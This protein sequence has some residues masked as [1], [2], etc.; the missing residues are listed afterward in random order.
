[1][2]AP[3]LYL[4]HAATSP[5]RPA[6]LAAMAAAW[7]GPAGNAAARH[8][9][10]RHA[11]RLVEDARERVAA[12]VGARPDDVIFT[13][14]ATEASNLAVRGA[15]H[16]RRMGGR[17]IAATAIEHAATRRSLEALAAEGW[18]V[19]LLEAD[20]AGRLRADALA[21]PLA[22]GTAV[23][24]VIA[25][26][27]ELGTVQ[28]LQALAEAA[29]A[30]GALLHLDAVQAAGY[31]DLA[32]VPWDLL[33]LSAHKLGGPPGVGALVR[34]DRAAVAPL[35]V[36]GSQEDGVRPGTMPVALLAG[37][38]AACEA[39]LGVR[40]VAAHDLAAWRDRLGRVLPAA[41]PGLRRVGAWA[42]GGADALPQV[43]AFLLAGVAGDEIV[44]ALDEAGVAAASASACLSG[45][46][47][48]TLDAIGAPEGAGLLR[49]SLGWTTDAA[50]IDAAIPRV[51][52]A[53]NGL[54]AMDAFARRRG[55]FAARAAVAGVALGEPHWAAAEAVHGFW[56]REGVLPGPRRLASLLPGG[57]PLEALFPFGLPTLAAWL[58][59]PIPRGGCRAA[60]G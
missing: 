35:L 32:G 53:L 9:E 34:R 50:T 58:G 54:L 46:R 10:G 29:H 17:R 43:A 40:A 56:R 2:T 11:R 30:V 60:L 51:A 4:D 27:N 39:A 49:L 55:P 41:V 52:T 38:G 42:D 59:L 19:R 12:L 14:G 15:A 33:S 45:A 23:L 1:M 7:S 16:A 28:P 8:A 47:T 13:A 20:A 57:P 25:G 48:P 44:H 18:Q 21:E 31:L 37:F 22:H 26:H 6:A 24:S 36:G 5:V 3:R